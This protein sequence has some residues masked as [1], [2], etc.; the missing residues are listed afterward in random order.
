MN[1]VGNVFSTAKL[2][3]NTWYIKDKVVD[4][5]NE[6]YH[7][8]ANLVSFIRKW[9]VLVASATIDEFE[10]ELLQLCNEFSMYPK[11]LEYVKETWLNK[12]KGSFVSAWTDKFMHFG[13]TTSDRYD[14]CTAIYVDFTRSFCFSL[15]VAFEPLWL[16]QGLYSF[17]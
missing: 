16:K 5:C 13:N 14:K 10:Q 4:Y 7:S 8:D 6:M 11:A 2:F 15:T 1:A 17:P 12:Y 9:D 3:L